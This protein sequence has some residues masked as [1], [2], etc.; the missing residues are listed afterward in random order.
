[1]RK[2]CEIKIVKN[3]EMID[4]VI[5]LCAP[6]WPTITQNPD[7]RLEALWE[8]ESSVSLAARGPQLPL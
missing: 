3:V 6:A 1:M 2:I 7:Q 5:V 4:G 8:F